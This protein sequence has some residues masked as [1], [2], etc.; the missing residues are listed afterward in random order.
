MNR[1]TAEN[2]RQLRLAA[3][4]LETGHPWEYHAL[5]TDAKPPAMAWQPAMQDGEPT[6][7]LEEMILAGL[8]FR[9]ILLAPPD[10]RRLHNPAGLDGLQVGPGW[11]LIL[12]EEIGQHKVIYWWTAA[13]WQRAAQHCESRAATYRVPATSPWPPAPRFPCLDYETDSPV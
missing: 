5:D 6:A 12:E 13:G 10:G 3:D 1:D 7:S 2:V 11:R 8:L 4:I 9:P